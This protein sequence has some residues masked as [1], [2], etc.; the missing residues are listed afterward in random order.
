M[1]VDKKMSGFVRLRSWLAGA[2]AGL[3][4]ALIVTF[5]TCWH[6]RS[7]YE[8]DVARR[9]W[10]AVTPSVEAKVSGSD[11]PTVLLLGD[12]RIG[13][14]DLRAASKGRYV[15]AGISGGTTAEVLN[16][17]PRLLEK[18]RPDLVVIEAGINDLKLLG[19]RPDLRPTVTARVRENLA[20]L[21]QLCRQRGSK[22]IVLPIWP[23]TRPEF[24]RRFV[25]N[26][27]VPESVEEINRELPRLADSDPGVT[28]VDLFSEGVRPIYRDTVHFDPQTYRE[29]T[30]LLERHV[31]RLFARP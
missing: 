12:S 26:R 17:A 2:F 21:I 7:G 31:E 5:A 22:V 18:F 30:P 23:P 24:R 20:A 19:V 9:V 27:A 1:R 13:Q 3:A 25:W 16:G 28:V 4:A 15:N 10:P 8:R 14:W 11:F 29:L 6:L